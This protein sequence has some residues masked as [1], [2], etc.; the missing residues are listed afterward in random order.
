MAENAGDADHAQDD[1][2]KMIFVPVYLLKHKK[3]IWIRPDGLSTGGVIL[4]PFFIRSIL[5]FQIIFINIPELSERRRVDEAVGRIAVCDIS[6][7][8]TV[9]DFPDFIGGFIGPGL[10]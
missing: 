6:D 4:L 8:L 3:T 9:L 1:R 2:M 5:L 10:P 7:F